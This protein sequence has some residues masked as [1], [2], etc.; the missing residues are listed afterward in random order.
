[1]RTSYAPTNAKVFVWPAVAVICALQIFLLSQH[2][3]HDVVSSNLNKNLPAI[4]DSAAMTAWDPK[5]N[6]LAIPPGQ[7]PNL[8][9]PRLQEGE[10]TSVGRRGYGGAGDKEHLGGF[11]EIDPG[12]ISPGLFKYMIQVWGIKSVVDIGCGRGFSTSW[13]Y[14]H[15]C[16]VICAEGS[17]DAIERT[18]LPDP[19]NQVVEHDFSRGP[20]WPAKTY[21]AAWS[22]EFLEHVGVEYQANYVAAFRKAALIFV[23]ASRGHGWHHVEVHNEAW[24]IRKYE[25]Y[26]LKFDRELTDKAKEIARANKKTFTGPHKIYMDGFYVR[27]AMMVFI[28]PVVASLPEHSHLFPEL[29][30]FAGKGDKG[31]MVHRD[32]SAQKGETVP[33]PRMNP[34]NLTEAMHQK[35]VDW[36]EPKVKRPRNAIVK[37]D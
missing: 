23:T 5:V 15:G 29:G 3:A 10:S 32:C 28:N 27:T 31:E 16:D 21:D 9:S 24:W 30:C 36:L 13:F 25:S 8:P 14:F 12:G 33:N 35:W 17:H 19:E 2:V 7:A 22:V 37:E 1:M 34:L 20:W 11:S 6:P 4:V 18:V 26:G